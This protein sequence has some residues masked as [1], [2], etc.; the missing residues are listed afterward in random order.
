MASGH[1]GS[2][3]VTSERRIRARERATQA[4]QLRLA[5]LTFQEIADQLEYASRATAYKATIRAL[6]QAAREPVERLREIENA[7]LDAMQAGAWTK[8][9][10]G[11][12][13]A[14]K[15]V[16]LIMERR[17]R[18]NGLDLQVPETT[19]NIGPMAG[20]QV[21]V[22]DVPAD[23]EAQERLADHC[24]AIE[25]VFDESGPGEEAPALPG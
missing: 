6:D 24:R 7:R 14:I 10:A 3:S 15:T 20:A 21:A 18:L 12:N 5:G 17:A 23:P 22:I 1:G 16:L 25:A 19:V 13:A 9:L 11:D 4:V 8:A 2:K